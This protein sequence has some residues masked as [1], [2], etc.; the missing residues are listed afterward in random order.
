VAHHVVGDGPVDIVFV[1][2]AWSHLEVECEL[3][4]YRRFCELLGEFA[5]VI[6]FDKR[7][8]PLPPHTWQL[9]E[10]LSRILVTNV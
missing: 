3:P 5:P 6:V 2:G 4:A 7:P 8:A 1:E 10:P 9:C